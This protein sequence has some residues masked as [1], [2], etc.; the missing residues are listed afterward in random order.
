ML[1]F[2]GGKDSAVLLH[3][4][5]KAFRPGG[6]PFP[7]LHVDTGHNFAEVIE[8]RDKQ[9]AE[10]GERL[11]VASVQDSI[12][13]GRVADPGPNA[14]PQPPPDHH[15]A[16]RHRRA[17]LRRLLSAVPGGTRTRPGPKSGC[18]RSATPSASGIPSASAPSCGSSTRVG[19][20]RA[21]TSGPSRSR[22]GPSSTSG[23][24]SAASGSPC[25]PSTSPTGARWS[26]ATAC[27]WP[28]ASGS[29]PDAGE[30][31]SE[32]TVRYRTVGDATCTGAVRSDG[33]HGG[34]D[35]R[36]GRRL[37]DLRTRCHPG[38]RPVLR[39]LDG[40]PQARR[41]LLGRGVSQPAV[42]PPPP[43]VGSRQG[44][45]SGRMSWTCCASPPS[46]RSTTAS[47]P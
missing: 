36:R 44:T 9:V 21:S 13:R 19:C 32:E 16:R 43:I 38:R 46:D 30:E 27:C 7:M 4:A 11:L 14:T 34:R 35:H 2:S 23:S 28:S 3:L 20:S 5:A 1:L 10:L 26:S 22:T 24:T 17:L 40:G 42:R 39:D 18:S 31:A 12:D 6:F 8:Y 47:R 29:R 41:V 37:A 45:V 15:P 33:H 25:R